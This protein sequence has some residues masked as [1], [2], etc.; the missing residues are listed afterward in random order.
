MPLPA[1]NRL[2]LRKERDRLTREGKSFHTRYFTFVTA[3]TPLLQGQALKGTNLQGLALKESSV[4]HPVPRFSI[5]LSKK[6]ARLA[7]D[8]N[9][10][11]RVASALLAELLP[12]FP[13]ADY[14]VI[15]KR[16]VLDTPHPNLL[17]DL[18]SLLPKLE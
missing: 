14:L 11:K 2:P 5:L 16:S 9:H 7:V 6:I 10:I 12:Q 18:K 1:I 8:R 17:S 13:P 3:P 4:I 15:P